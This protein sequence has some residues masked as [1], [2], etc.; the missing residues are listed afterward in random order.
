MRFKAFTC[1]LSV[2]SKLEFW[3]F[4]WNHP[5]NSSNSN[6]LPPLF[7]YLDF[8]SCDLNHLFNIIKHLIN[9]DQNFIIFVNSPHQRT[10]YPVLVIILFFS[11][12]LKYLCDF[13][14]NLINS[15]LTF[16]ISINPPPFTYP[17]PVLI[18]IFF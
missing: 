9:L 18:D 12:D 7:F 11:Y 3:Y 15:R 6:P 8:N 17:F 13:Y 2:F 10:P 5:P 16:I 4:R 1:C 14:K